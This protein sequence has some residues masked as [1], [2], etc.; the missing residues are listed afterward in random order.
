MNDIEPQ[1]KFDESTNRCVI[2]FGKMQIEVEP[3]FVFEMLVSLILELSPRF[4]FVVEGEAAYREKIEE[5]LLEVMID[6]F[7][8]RVS[9][10]HPIM[11]TSPMKQTELRFDGTQ[12]PLQ[13]VSLYQK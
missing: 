1:F 3:S 13:I 12:H 2:N 8:I 10:V 6:H 7:G 9:D 5:R 4:P 11:N